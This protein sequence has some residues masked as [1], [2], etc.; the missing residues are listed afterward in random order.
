MEIS[1]KLKR[2]NFDADV[3]LL[4]NKTKHY[5]KIFSRNNSTFKITNMHTF[6]KLNLK[7]KYIKK[8]CNF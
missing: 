6:F 2:L 5:E 1:L 3:I 4:K 7:D 8:V